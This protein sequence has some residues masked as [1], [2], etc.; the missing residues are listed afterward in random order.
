MAGWFERLTLG[1]PRKG[2]LRKEDMPKTRM[3]LFWTV[4][5]V[6]FWKL[7]GMNGL[8]LIFNLPVFLWVLLMMTNLSQVIATG[9]PSDQSQFFTFFLNQ[10]APIILTGA[11]VL[12]PLLVLGGLGYAGLAGV[13]NT[14]AYDEND[15]A[16]DGFWAGIKQHWKQSLGIQAVNGVVLLVLVNAYIFYIGNAADVPVFAYSAIFIL[17]LAL[18]FVMM[19]IFVYPLMATYRMK[20]WYLWR[21]S[22]WMAIGRFPF[23]LGVL[24]II[25]GLPVIIYA[26]AGVSYGMIALFVYFSLIG[27]ALSMLIATSY[28]HS[29]FDR[30]LN[31]RIPGAIIDR[32]LQSAHRNT[33][34][35]KKSTHPDAPGGAK[36]QGGS[37][38]GRAKASGKGKKKGKKG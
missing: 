17:M 29:V 8:W 22:F 7:F 28:A 5:K 33:M 32:G 14:W 10:M 13:M 37:N 21:N 26:I 9:M 16:W 35:A 2:D 36:G 19:N 3:E 1:D 27:G 18:I 4:L 34:A 15:W 23:A 12:I 20:F 24:L 11:M 31:P 38:A 25:V 30:Y 6:R